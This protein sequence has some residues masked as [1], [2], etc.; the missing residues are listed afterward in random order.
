MTF[1][2]GT[3]YRYIYAAIGPQQGTLDWM[4]SDSMK[5]P[6][7]SRFLRQVASAHRHHHVVMMLDGASSH[8]AAALEIP[9]NVSLLHLPRTR[10]NSTRWRS[11]GMSYARSA[12]PT[13]R[14]THLTPCR[15][16]SSPD[17][18][19]W[20]L[21]KTREDAGTVRGVKLA[22]RPEE[23][24]TWELPRIGGMVRNTYS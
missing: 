9:K 12:A 16:K 17:C 4:A 5:T 6:E 18:E 11:C 14:S 13:G 1:I 19:P 8:R 21:H 20:R 24:T 22:I 2:P 23:S 7:M 3:E 10:Q 15:Y